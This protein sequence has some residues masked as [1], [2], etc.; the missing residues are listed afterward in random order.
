[1]L[2]EGRRDG[3]HPWYEEPAWG[4]VGIFAPQS[5]TTPWRHATRHD[6]LAPGL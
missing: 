1:M 4:W 6:R 3:M 2:H 5:P